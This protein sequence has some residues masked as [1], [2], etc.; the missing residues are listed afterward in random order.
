MAETRP[1]CFAVFVVIREGSFL[2]D[3]LADLLSADRR[4]G[5]RFATGLIAMEPNHDRSKKRRPAGRL[6][7]LRYDIAVGGEIT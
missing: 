5:D 2:T 3:H 6:F 7:V 1:Q 4:C